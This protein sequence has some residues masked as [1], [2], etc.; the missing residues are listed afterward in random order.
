MGNY[1]NFQWLKSTGVIVI[2][3]TL[4]AVTVFPGFAY[5]GP[6]LSDAIL[7]LNDLPEGFENLPANQRSSMESLL[8]GFQRSLT[9]VSEAQ[10]IN[11]ASFWNANASNPQFVV[12]GLITPF[13]EDE[14]SELDRQ[15]ADPEALYSQLESAL[16][17]GQ[18]SALGGA[19]SIGD[20]RL[21]FSM[22]I[23]LGSRTMLLD[24]VVARRGPVLIE[25]AYIYIQGNVPAA[26]AVDLARILDDRVAAIVGRESGTAFR[27]GGP[28]V[29]EITRYIPA[30]TDLSTRPTVIGTN[31]LLAALMM[32]PFA[33]AA[34]VLTRTI[35]ENESALK[36]RFAPLKWVSRMQHSL[37]DY[38]KRR[39][40][41][42]PL[43]GIFKVAAVIAFYG[44][45]F[46]MLDRTWNPLSSQGIALFIYMCVAYGLVGLAGDFAQWRRIR[47]WGL[48]AE[49][50][51]KPTNVLLAVVSTT[52]SRLLSLVPGLMFGTPD[53]LE[54]RVEQFDEPKRNGL[55]KLSALTLV[56]VGLVV[57]LPTILMEIIQSVA[58]SIIIAGVEALLLTVAAVALENL[59]VKLIGLPGTFGETLKRKNRWLWMGVLVLVAFVF[60]HTL[61]N[62]RGELAEAITE[63]NVLLFLSIT[64]AFVLFTFGLRFYLE[65][66]KGVFVEKAVS[67]AAP[68]AAKKY[69][70]V[71]PSS[72]V[73]L[74]APT[75][76]DGIIFST[77]KGEKECPVCHNMIKGEARLCRHCRAAFN[78]STKGYCMTDHAV[79]DVEGGKCVLCGLA[80]KDVHLESFLI[81]GADGAKLRTPAKVEPTRQQKLAEKTVTKP[82]A[83]A[84]RPRPTRVTVYAI[85]LLVVGA[86]ML[87]ARTSAL[88]D[89]GFSDLLPDFVMVI[90]GLALLFS[91]GGALV[92]ILFLGPGDI[93]VT[94]FV[95]GGT[96]AAIN[97]IGPGI[98][99]VLDWIPFV[100]TGILAVTAIGLLMLKN[101]ARVAIIVLSWLT[102]AYLA[103]SMAYVVYLYFDLPNSA[104]VSL[105]P[106]II[107]AIAILGIPMS[108]IDSFRRWFS[109]NA[110]YFK[111]QPTFQEPSPVPVSASITEKKLPRA[112]A[113]AQPSSDLKRELL[114]KMEAYAE[115]MHF[116]STCGEFDAKKFAQLD[117][118]LEKAGAA[119]GPAKRGEMIMQSA[120]MLP[121]R[122]TGGLAELHVQLADG[123]SQG[124]TAFNELLVKVS[125]TAET[126][127]QVQRILDKYRVKA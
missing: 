105:S 33:F 78:V 42:N 96:A 23:E 100:L 8:E 90:L 86:T 126:A 120:L 19:G 1:H 123:L 114:K 113:Q 14:Q 21:A 52:T 88:L 37:S 101:W 125:P 73:A 4:A 45:V 110:Y 65:R 97:A 11:V 107:A 30:P 56:V 106:S 53:A 68:V 22:S 92:T 103:G 89:L 98:L 74:R 13:T 20:T 80:A 124:F 26:R 87:L 34:E 82:P 69:A 71:K 50:N 99:D 39:V 12:S 72:K 60:Y 108:V 94:A 55:L 25:L 58:T 32:L 81:K 66:N 49:L 10:M 67:Q 6:D 36:E 24:Y 28:L 122:S 61:I 121:T 44:L 5:Q 57:W 47:K 41:G 116:L 15:L 59:F 3:T 127:R 112:T 91:P 95:A 83:G 2:V 9:R 118:I 102:I 77:L 35:S 40:D 46:S 51:V 29:P 27:E 76:D 7:R 119:F 79:V 115:G 54:T 84:K 38:F 63:G 109:K 31:V 85:F 18:V 48:A 16:G 64:A 62:P 70:T 75:S 117:T 93:P 43:T 104:R 17:S 111:V